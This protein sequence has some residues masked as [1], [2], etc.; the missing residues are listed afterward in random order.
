M[1][2]H[3]TNTPKEAQRHAVPLIGMGVLLAIVLVGFLWWVANVLRG[4]TETDANPVETPAPAPT[5]E[6]VE[7]VTPAN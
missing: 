6:P 3:D 4:P 1:A 7:P 5:A 2:P